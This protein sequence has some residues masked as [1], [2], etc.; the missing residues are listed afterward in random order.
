MNVISMNLV[1]V[2]VSDAMVGKSSLPNLTTALQFFLRPERKSPLDVLHRFFQTR[3]WSDRCMEVV[4]HHHEVVQLE[5]AGQGVCPQ[6][7]D[8]KLGFVLRL[9]KWSIHIGLTS[10]EKRPPARDD[11]TPVGFSGE[12]YHRQRLKPKFYYGTL[13]ARLK[14]GP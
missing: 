14:P 13:P 3:I 2:C 8:K 4:G 7:V 10:G 6:D 1:V 9:E 12:L 11:I 5:L